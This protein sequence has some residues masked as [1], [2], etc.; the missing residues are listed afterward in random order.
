MSHVVVFIVC[1]T[2]T[3]CLFLCLIFAFLKDLV[4]STTSS[5]VLLGVLFAFTSRTLLPLPVLLTE[6]LY[7]NE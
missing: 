2:F 4:S 6:F 7:D 3:I 1:R 5:L